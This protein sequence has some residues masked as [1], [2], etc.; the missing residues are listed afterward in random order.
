[1][2]FLQLGSGTAFQIYA[3]R[4]SVCASIKCA[5]CRIGSDLHSEVQSTVHVQIDL[6]VLHLNCCL[7]RRFNSIN[8]VH[9][10]P[11]GWCVAGCKTSQLEQ[12]SFFGGSF[13]IQILA[14]NS[15]SSSSTHRD[16]INQV[17]HSIAALPKEKFR[18]PT[19]SWTR[20]Q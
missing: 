11:F 13:N 1:M 17:R 16:S 14:R 15:P 2:L 10:S 9:I 20:L 19:Q 12:S 5:Y 4:K 6:Y 7:Y 18:L 3:H 8:S